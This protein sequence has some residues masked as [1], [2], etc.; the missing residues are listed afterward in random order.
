MHATHS[1]IFVAFCLC[2]SLFSQVYIHDVCIT[3]L[4]IYMSYVCFIGGGDMF[5]QNV[6][7]VCMYRYFV[8]SLI[9]RMQTASAQR[10]QTRPFHVQQDDV[11]NFFHT[12]I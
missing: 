5:I 9:L 6:I 7:S 8:V 1:V 10:E 12:D 3:Y 2:S 11:R 4:F